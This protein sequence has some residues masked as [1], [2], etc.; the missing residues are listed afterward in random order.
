MPVVRVR[1]EEGDLFTLIEGFLT[2]EVERAKEA[3]QKYMESMGWKP[4]AIDIS[5]FQELVDKEFFDKAGEIFEKIKKE[6]EKY[7]AGVVDLYH[8][9]IWNRVLGY[10]LPEKV[11][12]RLGKH[13][14]EELSDAIGD[15][16]D[17]TA[18][19]WIASLFER[20]KKT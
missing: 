1:I 5:K 9:L 16:F 12:E 7:R 15:I 17:D 14:C 3:P 18:S 6:G 8:L 4:Y 10:K 13:A 20:S 19:N 2:S 11:V